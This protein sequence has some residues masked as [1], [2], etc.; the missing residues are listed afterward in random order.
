MQTTMTRDEL[1]ITPQQLNIAVHDCTITLTNPAKG[2]HRT[3]KIETVRGGGL[4]DK[5]II[6][7]MVG[8]DNHNDFKGFGF[9]GE[10]GIVRVWKRLQGSNGERSMYER[11]A[12]I[13]DRPCHWAS[14]GVTFTIS[15]N[16]RRCGRKLTN[17]TSLAT[18]LGPECV[19]KV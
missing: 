9:V 14:K 5:R 16:C 10:D 15:L 17:P 11:Y 8:T 7:L 12:D 2:T 18:G 13:F 6:S 1:T 19:K 4:D 3:F